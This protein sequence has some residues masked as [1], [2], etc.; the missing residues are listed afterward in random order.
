MRWRTQK[1]GVAS[2]SKRVQKHAPRARRIAP[3]T[4]AITAG[5]E[6][7]NN[8]YDT[9]PSPPTPSPPTTIFSTG[10]LAQRLTRGCAVTFTCTVHCSKSTSLHP[11]PNQ[12]S[13]MPVGRDKC[14]R[15]AGINVQWLCCT[16]PGRSTSVKH[17]QHTL[18]HSRPAQPA[19]SHVH[20]SP[21][22]LHRQEV[23]PVRRTD[24][25]HCIQEVGGVE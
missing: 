18:H 23:R 14:C 8:E 20:H 11:T 10:H 24:R 13:P 19:L 25:A 22:P 16:Q 21:V 4:A 2:A 7:N 5:K 1:I 12:T 3:E 15:L 17:C 6:D 9:P